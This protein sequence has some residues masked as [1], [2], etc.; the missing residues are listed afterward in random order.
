MKENRKLYLLFH[1][2]IVHDEKRIN[3]C[4]NSESKLSHFKKCSNVVA[5]KHF[6]LHHRKV[7]LISIL[8]S[9]FML[10]SDL[11]HYIPCYCEY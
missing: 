7:G 8:G 6:T 2:P 4:L 5:V 3:F 10:G 11:L 9:Y 1:I